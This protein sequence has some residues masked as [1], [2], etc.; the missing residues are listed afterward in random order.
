MHKILI[1]ICCC[2]SVFVSN[3]YGQEDS[4]WN[5]YLTL[6]FSSDKTPTTASTYNTKSVE[7]LLQKGNHT[8]VSDVIQRSIHELKGYQYGISYYKKF[9]WGYSHLDMHLSSSPILPNISIR[10][11]LFYLLR[12]GIVINAGYNR[13]SY[14]NG[15]TASILNLGTNIYYKSTLTRCT[16]KFTDDGNTQYIGSVRNYFKNEVDYLQFTVSNAVEEGEIL[17]NNNSPNRIY[18]YQLGG[19]KKIANKLQIDLSCGISSI[20]QSESK[21]NYLYYSVGLKRKL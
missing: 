9:N 12:K 7:L 3:S 18:S 11:K 13:F 21:N 16:V 2:T 15:V 19:V 14:Q 5:K 17:D 10:T 20:E 8:I 4:T 6:R 1:I